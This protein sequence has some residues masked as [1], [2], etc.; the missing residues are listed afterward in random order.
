MALTI[1]HYYNNDC[2]LGDDSYSDNC[3]VLYVNDNCQ[4]Y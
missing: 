1:M 2:M 3:V 4:Q